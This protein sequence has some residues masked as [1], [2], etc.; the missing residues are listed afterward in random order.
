MSLVQVHHPSPFLDRTQPWPKL[1]TNIHQNDKIQQGN[2][3]RDKTSPFPR[4]ERPIANVQIQETDTQ[5][6]Y[7]QPTPVP[8]IIQTETF[9]LPRPSITYNILSICSTPD[10]NT[11][12]QRPL[13]KPFRVVVSLFV[14]LYSKINYSFRLS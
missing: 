2:A 11:P 6:R 12:F 5:E 8:G 1:Y 7:L 14:V 10:P 13:L 3:S 9:I 4:E